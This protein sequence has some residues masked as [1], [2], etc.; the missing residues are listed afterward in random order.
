MEKLNISLIADENF[1]ATQI[2]AWAKTINGANQLTPSAVDQLQTAVNNL[3]D[4]LTWKD[5]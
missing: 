3:I 4:V 2:L 1:P 5:S